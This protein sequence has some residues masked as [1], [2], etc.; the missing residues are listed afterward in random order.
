MAFFCQAAKLTKVWWC[1]VKFESQQQHRASMLGEWKSHT[2]LSLSLFLSLFVLVWLSLYTH[3]VGF[4]SFLPSLF[5]L[6]FF[7]LPLSYMP[8]LNNKRVPLVTPPPYD[9]RRKRKEVWYLRFTNEI[10]TDY[11]Y[12]FFAIVASNAFFFN[13]TRIY[14]SR[15]YHV[16][17]NTLCFYV[18][19]PRIPGTMNQSLTRFQCV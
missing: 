11:E 10:F 4:L 18:L 8:L 13:S 14:V 17:H 6:H 3:P 19:L 2:H 15:E 1:P 12:P 16:M 5:T 9:A 7:L